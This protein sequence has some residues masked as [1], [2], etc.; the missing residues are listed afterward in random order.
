MIPIKCRTSYRVVFSGKYLGLGYPDE[1]YV[2]THDKDEVYDMFHLYLCDPNVTIYVHFHD[3]TK[4]RITL[5]E[6]CARDELL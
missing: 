4:K 3:G 2:D 1:I 5:E 6:Y